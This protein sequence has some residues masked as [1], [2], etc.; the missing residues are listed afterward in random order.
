MSR[1]AIKAIAAICAAVVTASGLKWIAVLA[2]VTAPTAGVVVT[3]PRVEVTAAALASG[4]GSLAAAEDA[5][6]KR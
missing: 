4:A 6:D 3:L 1:T 2:T 5:G